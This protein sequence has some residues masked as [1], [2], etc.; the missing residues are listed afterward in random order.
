MLARS[1]GMEAEN[2]PNGRSPKTLNKQRESALIMRKSIW[3]IGGI[4]VAAAGFTAAGAMAERGGDGWQGRHGGGGWKHHRRSEGGHGY[5]HGRHDGKGRRGRRGPMTKEDFDA[6]TRARFARWD[7]NG[8]GVVDRA[9]AEKRIT[10]RMERRMERR[11]G[12]RGQGRGMRMMN[13]F[14]EDRDGT[15]TKAEIETYITRMFTRMDLDGDGRITDADLPPMMRGL[16]IIKGERP[17]FAMGG[18]RHEGR[19]MHGRHGGV[20]MLRHML[21]ADTNKDGEITIEEA[22]AIGAKRAARFDR[23]NDGNIDQA[24]R[25]AMRGEM[26]DYRVRRFLHRFGANPDTGLTLEQ[27]TTHRNERF[28]R[29]DVD[30]DGVLSRRERRGGGHGAGRGG[31][32][33]H[34]RGGRGR[35]HGGPRGGGDG[36]RGGQRQ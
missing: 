12:G 13:R 36:E 34:E 35:G 27:F 26:I 3:I 14:D 8:D 18:G 22:Q 23:N 17:H 15:V 7:E 21:G 16:D 29:R 32:S 19:R 28:A 33:H 20:P 25:D 10:A 30:G 9:E 11:G 5:R 6:Q 4:A 24:D 31:R 1:M 2:R